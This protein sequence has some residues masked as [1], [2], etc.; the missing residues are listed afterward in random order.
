MDFAR[1]EMLINELLACMHLLWVH[2]IGFGH[3]GNKGLL[4]VNGMVKGLSGGKFPIL[5]FVEHPS[6]LSVL[7]R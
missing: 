2:R 7:Q 4:E 1:F 5:W 6:I 3:F